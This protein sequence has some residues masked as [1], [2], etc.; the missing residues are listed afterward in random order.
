MLSNILER[1]AEEIF[2]YKAYPKDVDFSEVPEALKKKHP[3]LTEPGSYNG[4]YGWKQRLKY[5]MANY[6]A[7]LKTYRTPEVAVN[8]LKVKAAEDALPAKKVKRPRRSELNYYPSL[9]SGETPQS[10]EKERVTFDRSEGKKN[11][12]VIA[13]KMAQTFAYRRQKVVD[14]QPRVENVMTR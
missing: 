8:S 9:P 10:M 14:Q 11:R 4:C 5:K 1:L 7:Q 6:R 12:R 2:K 3:C 13:E